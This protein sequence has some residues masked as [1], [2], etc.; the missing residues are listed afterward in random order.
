MTAK[1]YLRLGETVVH[2][3]LENGLNV[4]INRKSGF[5]KSY[6]FFAANYGGIDMRF[7][8]DGVWRNT[9]A[10]VAHFLEHKM[11]DTKDGNALQ[12]LTANGADPNA[13]T[14]FSMTGY[15]FENTEKFYDNLRILLSFVSEPYFTQESVEKEQGIIAQEIRMVEDDPENQVFY[16]M[17]EG[18]YE[19]HPIRT[20]IA[21]TV[22]SI[23]HITSDTLY[24]CHRAFYPPANMVLCVVGDVDPEEVCALARDILP[25]EKRGGI[26]RDYGGKERLEAVQSRR[27]LCM[28]VST[29]IF[30]AGWK[31]EPAVGADKLRRRLLGELCCE[32]LFGTS[33][34]LYAKLYDQ[35]LV[36][37]NFSYGCEDYPGCTFLTLGGESRDPDAVMAAVNAEA[38]RLRREGIDEAFFRRLKKAAYGAN[39]RG[40]NSFENICVGMAQAHFSGTDFFSFPE[41]FETIEK[42]DAE[43][44]L[45]TC[46]T[47]LR[48]ALA[49]V[50]PKEVN[51]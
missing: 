45:Q 13:F 2:E 15:Y 49:I 38:E 36:N 6:A 46:V 9:P 3:T 8:L 51:V 14:S 33:S 25:K 44:F 37:K 50:K 1:E 21:G 27:E 34:P 40:L 22:E 19:H 4:Y 32:V 30:Q 7:Q 11:F 17:L 5:Q 35:G 29:P 20:A 41:V 23:S 42:A 26:S 43:E 28:E 24:A 16:A 39:V 47:P 12:K 48:S 18:L 31:A 10:G